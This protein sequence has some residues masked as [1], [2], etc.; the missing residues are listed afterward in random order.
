MSII[1][2]P[3]FW[4]KNNLISYLLIIPSLFYYVVFKILGSLRF[5]LQPV[6]RLK[7]LKIICLGNLTLGGAGKTPSSIFI[8]KLLSEAG[9]RVV[10]LTKGY[11]RK[12]KGFFEV[13]ANSDPYLF[14]DEP[15]LLAKHFKTF[16]YSKTQQVKNLEKSELVN[17]FDFVIMDDGIHNKSIKKDFTFLVSDA[18]Y[19]NGNG[20]LFPAGPL[21]SL[22][23]D[24]K[25][26]ANLN[27]AY[28][29]F[30]NYKQDINKNNY[31]L[32]ASI[33][34]YEKFLDNSNIKQFNA[35]CAIARPDKFFTSL[36]QNN[37]SLGK[38]LSFCDHRL[39]TQDD[40][41]KIQS[42]LLTQ[43]SI[44]FTTYK[45]Y[46]KISYLTSKFTEYNNLIKNIVPINLT[47]DCNQDTKNTIKNLILKSLKY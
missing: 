36:K 14:G 20:F 39:Y 16:V 38:T 43:N 17:Q 21:R 25:Y 30:E 35:F 23:R 47:I 34:G 32:K 4:S 18:S 27:I 3:K 7:S 37:I 5:F 42:Q 24:I 8:A 11:G 26:D 15:V 9:Y 13:F 28:N 29:N 40:L 10:F 46:V 22:A 12:K 33:S 1:K 41:D 2:T 44:I 6:V 45:D 19:K 31:Y